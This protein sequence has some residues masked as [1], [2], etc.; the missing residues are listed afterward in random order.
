MIT[1]A[2]TAR[3]I[4]LIVEMIVASHTGIAHHVQPPPR[5]QSIDH[6]WVCL[7]KAL[8]LSAL[9]SVRCLK[10]ITFQIEWLSTRDDRIVDF[11]YPILSCFWKM[12]SVRG[13]P[14]PVANSLSCRISNWQTG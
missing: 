11:N 5:F 7:W 10:G 13:Y 3:N 6:C 14:Y 4:R 2:A 8:S 12:I 9:C 1:T